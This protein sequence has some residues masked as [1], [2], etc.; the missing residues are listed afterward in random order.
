MIRLRI[1]L[2]GGEAMIEF[3][4]I[5]SGKANPLGRARGHSDDAALEMALEIDHQIEAAGAHSAQEWHERPWG[6]APIVN[7]QFVEPG[8]SLDDRHRLGLDRPGDVRLRPCAAQTPEQ[9]Q[10]AHHVADRAE[11]DYQDAIGYRRQVV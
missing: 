7:D 9:R 11:Q 4:G 10:R 8:M 5:G 2:A 6:A 1:D 3:L